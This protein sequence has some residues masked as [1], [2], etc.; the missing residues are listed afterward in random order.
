MPE[1]QPVVTPLRLTSISCT[2]YTCVPAHCD[3]PCRSP[4]LA[5]T[6]SPSVFL[7]KLQTPS[8]KHGRLSRRSRF[9]VDF[10]VQNRTAEGE[11]GGLP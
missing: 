5:L 9:A 1:T 10:W 4:S 3:Q 7:Q 6:A 8:P 2:P 11:D